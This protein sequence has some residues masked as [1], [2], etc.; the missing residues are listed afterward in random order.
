[1]VCLVE[2]SILTEW[3][4]LPS[5]CISDVV[6]SPDLI[7]VVEVG[8]EPGQIPKIPRTGNFTPES[9]LRIS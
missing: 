7:K 8:K 5:T 2:V 1:M 3:S 6:R 9:Q 4:P